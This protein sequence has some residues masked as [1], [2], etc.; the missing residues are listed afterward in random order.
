[1]FFIFCY[2]CF[3]GEERSSVM[4]EV[5]EESVWG[6]DFVYEE[7]I[8]CFSWN[9]TYYAGSGEFLG[10]W[11]H[12]VKK[13]SEGHVSEDVR[14]AVL[15]AAAIFRVME[16]RGEL[17]LGN[18]YVYSDREVLKGLVVALAERSWRGEYLGQ[19]SGSN[20]FYV[21]EVAAIL[22]F[23]L[24]FAL[25]LVDEA[26]REGKIGLTGY[27]LIPHENEVAAK[28]RLYER[29]GHRSL[30]VSDFGYWSCSSCGK[31]GD[32]MTNPADFECGKSAS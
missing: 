29:T 21:Q 11:A 25:E 22:D 28:Q 2:D 23:S 1:M 7:A 15:K 3:K 26:R 20:N 6:M 17:N 19:L 18:V 31:S 14:R 24:T 9:K 30:S 12:V 16:M 13:D 27:I 5:R 8:Y 32:D 4:V 10:A